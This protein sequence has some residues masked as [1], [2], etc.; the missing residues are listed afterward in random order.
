MSD[1]VDYLEVDKPIPG[2]RYVCLSFV[3]PEKTLKEKELFLFNKFM[4]Q[5]CGEWELK[6]DEITKDCSEDYKSKIHEKSPFGDDK[7]SIVVIE[8]WVKFNNDNSF[9]EFNKLKNVTHYYR[10]DL[11][12]NPVL[13][14]K[15]KVRMAPTILI[16][17][18]GIL[19][20]SFR[21]GLDLECPVT[22]K[23]LQETIKETRLSNQF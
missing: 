16:F 9:K 22:L 1:S 10:C 13:K 14:K 17:K 4:N 7:S 23:E 5:R 8:F 19:E 20:E 11:A 2:Q 15:Y 18:D 6:L 3:S 21:A 12:S